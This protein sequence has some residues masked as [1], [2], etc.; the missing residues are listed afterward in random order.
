MNYNQRNAIRA[1]VLIKTKPGTAKRTIRE[2]SKVN[3]VLS[4]DALWGMYDGI[5]IVEAGGLNELDEI[6]CHNI[7]L[8]ENV[9]DT[10]TLINKDLEI[11]DSPNESD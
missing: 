8:I 11:P 3:G 9:K 7:K 5:A 1:Y 2:V 4:S 10:M 6:V